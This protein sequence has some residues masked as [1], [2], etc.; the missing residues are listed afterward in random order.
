MTFSGFVNF[1]WLT[2]AWLHKRLLY[3]M[4]GGTTRGESLSNI[5]IAATCKSGR[6]GESEKDTVSILWKVQRSVEVN[7]S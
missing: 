3:E 1:F 5:G 7:F 2:F 6:S 4:N